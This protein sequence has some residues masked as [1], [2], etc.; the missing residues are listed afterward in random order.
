[1]NDSIDAILT[2]EPG[3]PLLNH[4]ET[5]LLLVAFTALPGVGA[6]AQSQSPLV[7]NWMGT[8][9]APGASLRLSLAVAA[10]DG[11]LEGTLTS[12]DQGNQPMALTAVSLAGEEVTFSLDLLGASFA[13]TM[14]AR[15]ESIS[16]TFSQGGAELPL[17]INRV[18]PE[19]A[20]PPRP[21]DPVEPYPYDSEEIT[22]TNPDGGHTL[23]GTLTTPREGGPAPVVIL[24]SG[25]GPQDRNEALAGHRP[26]LVLSDHFTRAGIAVLRFDDRG[27]GGSNGDFAAATSPDFASDVVAAVRFLLGK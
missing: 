23:A 14:D 26:F 19:V 25:S 8:L 12:I 9:E 22:F 17:T 27:V 24:I 4:L 18:A 10:G 13:G 11:G 16:G 20:S 2:P 1:M 6:L 21:Q 15:Q 5:T 7:G 3:A